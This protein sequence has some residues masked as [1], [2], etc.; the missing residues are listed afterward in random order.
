M[1]S[2]VVGFTSINERITSINVRITS[3]IVKIL[4]KANLQYRHF[5]SLKKNSGVPSKVPCIIAFWYLDYCCCC[6]VQTVK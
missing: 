5:C 4:L 6:N 2:L 1:K 3:I